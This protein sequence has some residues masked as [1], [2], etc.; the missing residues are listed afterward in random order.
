MSYFIGRL[1]GS[2]ELPSEYALRILLREAVRIP[3]YNP[4]APWREADVKWKVKRGI[5]QGMRKP[6]ATIA[7]LM[8]ELD[9][10]EW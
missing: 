5:E 1:I 10:A 6:W 4:A 7:D 2:G 9:A 3:S 8:R